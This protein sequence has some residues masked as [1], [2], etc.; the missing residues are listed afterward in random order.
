MCNGHGQTYVWGACWAIC[1]KCRS[2]CCGL[3]IL[4]SEIHVSNYKNTLQHSSWTRC[5]V[6]VDFFFT[7]HAA[8]N[9]AC[10]QHLPK[11]SDRTY[12]NTLTHNAAHCNILKHT[13]PHCNALQRTAM[14]CI[15]LNSA[16]Q[17]CQYASRNDMIDHTATHC[18][19][20]QQAATWKRAM[21]APPAEMT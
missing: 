17:P 19:T 4:Y 10:Q 11:W 20:L 5:A 21:S 15:A 6:N 18:N 9:Y 2:L 8:G 14:Y 3:I 12:C 1:V 16:R 13:A 7:W